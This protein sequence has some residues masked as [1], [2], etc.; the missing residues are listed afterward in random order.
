MGR[1][2]SLLHF[3][4]QLGWPMIIAAIAVVIALGV[5]ANALFGGTKP[6]E[7][8]TPSIRSV[9]VRSVAELSSENAPLSIG[10]TVSSKSEASVHAESGGRVTAIYHNLGD[11]V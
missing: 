3:V 9:E 10:G 5:G 1:L 7:Q 4:R 8:A 2:N 6:V 11:S